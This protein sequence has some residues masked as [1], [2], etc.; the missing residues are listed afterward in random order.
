MSIKVIEKSLYDFLCEEFKEAESQIQIFRG[1]LP[2]RR[3]SEIDKNSGQRKSL[4]PCVTLRLLN[5]RQ[6]TE[7]MDSY[8]C[9]ATFEIIVGTKNED[10]IENLY[11]GEEIRS[12]LLTKV[13]DERGWA[14]RE[15]KEFKCDLYSDEFG[16]FI[17]SRITF[18]VWD[19][20][21]EPEILKEE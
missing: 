4:F 15:D 17:F 20:P 11:K 16:D 6:I 12:K 14:I 19:Y 7:G 8:D 13:Y 3:Y 21:I 2:I 5:S 10:Y 1:A 18:T 9:D